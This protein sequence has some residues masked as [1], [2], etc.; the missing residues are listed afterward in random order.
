MKTHFI[1]GNVIGKFVELRGTLDSKMTIE[2]KQLL[3]GRNLKERIIFQG[4]EILDASEMI[5]MKEEKIIKAC[6]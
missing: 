2:Q 1:N 3:F 6:T 4:E 5:K